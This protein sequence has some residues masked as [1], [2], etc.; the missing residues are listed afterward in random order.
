MGRLQKRH[1]GAFKT[2]RV[3]DSRRKSSSS[4]CKISQLTSSIPQIHTCTAVEPLSTPVRGVFFT[5]AYVHADLQGF[6]SMWKGSEGIKQSSQCRAAALNISMC[7]VE[8]GTS[9]KRRCCAQKFPEPCKAGV[10][11]LVIVGRDRSAN[12]V[13]TTRLKDSCRYESQAIRII[14]LR[15]QT[16]EQ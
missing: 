4:S 9:S 3:T 14:T 10:R 2:L 5:Q 15:A 12:H 13:E 8:D 6:C 16:A 11:S 7:S 1:A